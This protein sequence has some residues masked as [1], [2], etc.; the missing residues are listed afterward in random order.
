MDF[1]ALLSS[2]YA[3]VGRANKH[4]IFIDT[5]LYIVA[6]DFSSLSSRSGICFIMNKIKGMVGVKGLY[7]N[8]LGLL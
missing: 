2:K 1:K 7:R 8:L 5:N 3:D 6:V 4:G